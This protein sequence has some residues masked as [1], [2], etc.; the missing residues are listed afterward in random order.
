LGEELYL[1][2][3]VAYEAIGAVLIKKEGK[4]HKPIYF[5]SKALQGLELNYQNLKKVA[6]ALVIV[7]EG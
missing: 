1:Y 2:L 5:V 3:T 6:Y 7:E 4:E